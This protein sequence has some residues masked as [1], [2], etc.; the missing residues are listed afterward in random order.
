MSEQ[1]VQEVDLS[2]I[3]RVIRRHW[4]WILAVPVLLGALAFFWSRSQ[5]PV[6]QATATLI[7]A[8]TSVGQENV[9]GGAVVK[10]PPLP[11]GAVA[12]AIQSDLI[13]RPL[14][15]DLNRTVTLPAAERQRLT[16]A[17]NQELMDQN[18]KTL[19]LTSRLDFNGNGIYSIRAKARTPEAAQA[20]A[21]L[22]S[23]ALIAWD[24]NRGL[25]TIRRGIEGFTAQLVQVD[26]QLQGG[27]L[28]PLERQ[29]LLARRA[30][31]Q[32][33]RAQLTIL[34]NSAVG[35]LS[36]LSSAQ[37]PGRPVAPK[38]LRNA[39]LAGVLGL[40][41]A[42]IG[43]AL[44]NVFDRTIRNEDDLLSLEIPTLATLPRLRQRDVLFNGIVR[45][46]R[47]AGLYEAIGFL[48][49]NL[50]SALQHKP[51]PIVMVTSTAPREGKSS[52]TAT[53]ADGLASSGQRVLVIDADLRRGT[54]AA[55]WKKYDE[56]GQWRQL[57]GVGGARTTREALLSPENVQVLHVAENLDML[58]AG[59]GLLDSLSV[60]NQADL[61][62]ILHAWRQHYD[63]VLI[64]S[65]PLLALADG[66]VVGHHVDAVL[67]V[68]EYG[69]TNIQALRHALRRAH[70]TDLKIMGFVINKSDKREE[71]SYGY[72]YSYSAR[73]EQARV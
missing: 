6:Y 14:L 54:Q 40:L 67:M 42:L 30:R 44:A 61:A 12:Q 50:L 53:L 64:D 10:A 27:N 18:L 60:F 15:T 39:V 11:E 43:A 69:Q 49:V 66:L 9:V 21:N 41:L 46:A 51:H 19:S 33:S 20:L 35:V 13:L 29:T 7:A 24:R 56:A 31:I 68:V 72:S 38:P 17:L 4:I 58:P 65:A 62:T 52:V 37:L 2:S 73:G 8:N 70:R 63:M 28:S 34:E 3:W 1:R 25:E 45:A 59:P 36:P 47:Q 26:E 22:T 57:V 71:S 48:R 5:P 23:R 16:A 32:D 55:V